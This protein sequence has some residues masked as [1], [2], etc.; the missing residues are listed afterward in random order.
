MTADDRQPRR[1][2]YAPPRR[3]S[4]VRILRLL[5]L[6][7]PLA[8][9]DSLL[10]VD[11]PGQVVDADLN[12]PALAETLVLSAVGDF[13]CAFRGHLYGI[14]AGWAQLF[15]Y[16]DFLIELIRL[17]TRQDR[18]VELGEGACTSG[19]QPVWFPMQLARTQA[20][21]AIRRIQ[22]EMP[23]G[24]V[25]D[26]DLLLGT[27]FAYEGYATQFLAE[28]FC[29]VVFD[30]DEVIVSRA[31]AMRR[32][33]DR[34]TSAL[35]FAQQALTGPR[36][37]EA[38][39]IVDMAL[40]G[41]ARARLNLGD[42][43]ASVMADAGAVTAGF[44][45]FATFDGSPGRR[46]NPVDLL[47]DNYILHPSFRSLVVGSDPDPRVPSVLKP[48]LHS[49]GFAWWIQTKFTSDA[50]DIPLA[51]WREAQLMIAEVDPTSSVAII[52]D[53]RTN[54]HGLD[55]FVSADLVAIAAQVIE[56]RRRELFLQGTKIGD[57][58]RTGEWMNWDTDNNPIGA[59][60]GGNSCVP[61]PDIE[62]L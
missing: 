13:E 2:R 49:T 54:P 19:R 17:G 29:G 39:D 4:P 56:E 44:V 11:L 60:Y 27:A 38:Q 36:A 24:S 51:T 22:E 50:D 37:A 8:A 26:Q 15:H 42:P 30:G 59:P 3:R 33:E 46:N 7:I 55:P 18:V 47:E 10:E 31:D 6:V 41:R 34:F 5:L 61:V 52:N 20:S 1:Y 16:H 57:D 48:E 40:V 35:Q 53:L 43:A 62:F 45:R 25:E 23:A 14:E 28:T 21:E 12:N 58:L 32:A 9:C